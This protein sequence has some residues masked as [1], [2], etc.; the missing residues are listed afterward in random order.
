MLLDILIY[1]V[2][3]I[4]VV[5]AVYGQVSPHAYWHHEAVKH[6]VTEGQY[7]G[8]SIDEASPWEN[9]GFFQKKKKSVFSNLWLPIYLI[10]LEDWL[11]AMFAAE[12]NWEIKAVEQSCAYCPIL[13]SLKLF[14]QIGLLTLDLSSHSLEISQRCLYTIP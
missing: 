10:L 6:L 9:T 2:F 8:L 5:I 14:F 11:A 13:A 7:G 1:I 3:A 12:R 4:C